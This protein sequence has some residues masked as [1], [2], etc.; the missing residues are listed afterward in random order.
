VIRTL[1]SG[2]TIDLTTD[3]EQLNM[4]VVESDLIGSVRFDYD[5]VVNYR[6]ENLTPFSIENTIG[7]IYQPWTPTLGLHTLTANAFTGT[8]A[9][10]TLLNALTIDFHVVRSIPIDIRVFLEGPYDL[11]TNTM[12]GSL[13][14]LDLLPI[15]QPY[16]VAPWNYFGTEGQG[17]TSSEYP[18]NVI[19][20]VKVSF[21]TDITK[22]TE[23]IASAAILL[24]D[25]AL[26]FPNPRVLLESMGSSFYIVIQH[27][28]HMGI[29]SPIS[30][31]PANE[32]LTYNFCRENSYQ[33]GSGQKQLSP[34]LWAM[35]AGDGNQLDNVNGYDINGLDHAGWNMQNGLFDVYSLFDYNFDGDV[36]GMDKILWNVNNGVYSQVEK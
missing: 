14:Q 27:R 23:V 18:P 15:I 21:R 17:W 34:G 20:W 4:I 3:G 19:D 30:V 10:G 2:D 6:I 16:G 13:L 35:F 8:G 11:N 12:T 28:N 26:V 24:N 22:N 5:G 36:N 9:T 31:A 29:L 1:N 7:G 25:G 33:L 32:V